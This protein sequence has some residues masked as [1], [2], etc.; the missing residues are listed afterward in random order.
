MKRMKNKIIKGLNWR[1]ESFDLCT[2]YDA[3]A[4]HLINHK[5]EEK[6]AHGN[7]SQNDIGQ[8]SLVLSEKGCLGNKV[9]G[10]QNQK[11]DDRT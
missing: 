3:S 5:I 4:V 8:D 1:K 2:I 10:N 6:G 7:K 9:D 11:G